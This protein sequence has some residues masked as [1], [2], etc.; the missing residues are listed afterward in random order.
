MDE[1]RDA[2]TEVD[3]SQLAA[4][5]LLARGLDPCIV[6]LDSEGRETRDSGHLVQQLAPDIR[7]KLGLTN[8]KIVNVETRS[9]AKRRGCASELR[10]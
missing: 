1:E 5:A 3:P 2:G 6:E 9:C 10:S 7:P 4:M 8:N